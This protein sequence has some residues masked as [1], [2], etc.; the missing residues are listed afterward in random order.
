VIVGATVFSR[1]ADELER[2]DPKERARE[3]ERSRDDDV[4]ALAAGE[5]TAEQLHREN[6]H[7]TFPNAHISLRG[8]KSLE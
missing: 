2:F 6:G 3:K 4:R 7:F 5:K 1:M 8:T